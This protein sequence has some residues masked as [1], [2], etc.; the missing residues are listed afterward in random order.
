M[1][2][3]G[4]SDRV[5]LATVV[6]IFLTGGLHVLRITSSQLRSHWLDE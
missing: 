2:H 6:E 1:V 5:F 4:L 3:K